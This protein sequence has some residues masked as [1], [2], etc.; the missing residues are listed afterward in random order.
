MPFVKRPAD[1]DESVRSGER[2]IDYVCRMAY[3]KTAKTKD[4]LC[5]G[6]DWVL[7][8]DTVVVFD[9]EILGKPQSETEAVDM[10]KKLSGT[11]HE[12]ITAIG[13]GHRSSDITVLAER[14]EVQF[15]RI[16]V[17][18][19]V[20]YVGSG[21]PF[22]KAGGYGIQDPL[23]DF[24]LNL[25]GEY[26]TVVGLP[27]YPVGQFLSQ[28]GLVEEGL[29]MR[30]GQIRG[31]VNAAC[32]GDRPPPLLIGASKGQGVN[33]VNEATS[34]GLNHFGESYVQEMSRKVEQLPDSIDW[35]FIGRIQTNKL[36]FIAQQAHCVHTISTP[37]HLAA[38]DR[39]AHQFGKKIRVLFQVNVGDEET[40]NGCRVEAL[41]S[42]MAFASE[43]DALNICGLMTLPPRG[44]FGEAR[45]YFRTLQR[46]GHQHFGPGVELSMGMSGDLEAGISEGSTMI[47]VGSQLFGPR[48]A[49]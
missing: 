1:I 44:T 38:L 47:R 27:V 49:N 35:H 31:R 28:N 2:A 20:R 33:L 41:P 5:T 34:L 42:L 45:Q 16:Q 11:T 9:G 3:E 17:D 22:D 48:V 4:T 6:E 18:E 15:R 10:L 14:T 21:K 29:S 37:K 30:L 7:G 23:A 25:T 43:C 36:K 26:S 40:K 39:C 8:A 19:M 24:V 32:S 12:V 13:F 46:L